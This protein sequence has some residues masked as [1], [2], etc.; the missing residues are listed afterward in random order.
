MLLHLKC[1]GNRDE[2]LL[3]PPD[4]LPCGVLKETPL[5]R[6]Y[7][8]QLRH[9]RVLL[10]L[11]ADKW[12][13]LVLGVLCDNSKSVRFN[14]IKRAIPG[15]TQKSL[16][17]CLR[18][19]ERSGLVGRKVIE[20]APIGVE[21]SFTGLGNTLEAPISALFAWTG[22]HARAVRIAQARYDEHSI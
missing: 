13:M 2:T 4:T 20:T 19:L 18:R 6:A 7:D 16:T 10:D 5:S 9:D 21:Y 15:I 17:Q 12:T 14:A 3:C 11:I 22:T 1:V 8:P